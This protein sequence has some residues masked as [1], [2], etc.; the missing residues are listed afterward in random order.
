MGLSVD[1]AIDGPGR[2]TGATGDGHADAV[3]NGIDATGDS[4]CPRHRRCHRAMT[5][6]AACRTGS[7]VLR[8][9]WTRC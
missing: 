9:A 4:R 8:P 5:A 6:S 2:R 3:L 1:Q 7:K